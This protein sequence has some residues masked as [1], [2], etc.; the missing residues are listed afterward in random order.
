MPIPAG[1]AGVYRFVIGTDVLNQVQE[2]ISEDNNFAIDDAVVT[3][4]S[5]PAPNLIIDSVTALTSNLF[6]GQ[7]ATVEWVVRNIGNA[8]T[9]SSAW[10]DRVYLSTDPVFSADDVLLG[11]ASNP[12]FLNN[13]DAYRTSLTATLPEDAVGDRYFIVVTDG[14]NVVAETGGENDNSLASALSQ[15]T[16]TPPPDLFI[17]SVAAPRDAFEGEPINISWTVKNQ[18]T[19]PTR[20]NQWVDQVYLSLNGRDIDA[21]DSLLATVTR[22]GVLAVGEDYRLI[23]F[24]VTLPEIVLPM[25]RTSSSAPMVRAKYMNIAS[26]A[27]T[28]H[29]PSSP[30]A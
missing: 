28:I 30:R 23:N 13:G 20:V 26:K 2:F 11:R 25:K 5:R 16:L 6:S 19:G 8:S 17:T 3:I 18:G 24:S 7:S 14:T 10:E 1:L 12:S 22:N 29:Q 21:S 9:N 15:I 27:I 4:D